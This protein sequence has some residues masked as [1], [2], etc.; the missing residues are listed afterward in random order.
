MADH[1]ATAVITAPATLEA[2]YQFDAVV[3]GKL[4]K[5]EKNVED[6]S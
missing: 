2:G 1:P 5:G 3:D 4:F 6:A